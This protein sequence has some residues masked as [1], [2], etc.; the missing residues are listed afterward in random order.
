MLQPEQLQQDESGLISD[1]TPEQFGHCSPPNPVP[2]SDPSLHLKQTN[3]ELDPLLQMIGITA[4]NNNVSRSFPI[5]F[6]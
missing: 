3:D 6:F 5:V 4:G 1:M 2:N